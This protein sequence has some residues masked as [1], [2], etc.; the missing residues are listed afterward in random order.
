MR[1]CSNSSWARGG[2]IAHELTA[3]RDVFLGE[4]PETSK[5]KGVGNDLIQRNVDVGDGFRLP[6]LSL[7]QE[8]RQFGRRRARMPNV[9]ATKYHETWII[10]VPFF[11]I[12]GR[13]CD[14]GA[15]I[16]N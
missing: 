12:R 16:D 1:N 13:Q 14:N 5:H 11:H 7:T 6:I 15:T 2:N 4:E 3:S 8:D 10:L 9:H